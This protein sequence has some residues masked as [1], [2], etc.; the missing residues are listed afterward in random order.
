MNEQISSCQ[1]ASRLLIDRAQQL[2][3]II[4]EYVYRL[5]I[6]LLLK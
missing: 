4:Q 3:P 1:E 5:F 2:S 6:D